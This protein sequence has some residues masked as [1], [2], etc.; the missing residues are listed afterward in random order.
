MTRRRTLLS[1]AAASALAACA[2]DVA[3]TH[4]YTLRA[5]PPTPVSPAASASAATPAA[6]GDVWELSPAVR[7]P[8]ALDRDTLLVESGS[9]GLQPLV[10]HRWAEPLRDSVPRLLLQ[11]LQRLRGAGRVW[12]APA[13]PGVVVARKLTVEV[14]VLQADAAR[15]SLRMRARWWFED[16][17]PAATPAAPQIGEADVAIEIA[18]G[19]VDAL[20]AAHRL[21]LWRLAGFV[22]R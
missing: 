15:R 7:L 20:A 17:A 11:D 10:G 18:D 8:G 4:W 1:L 19:S 22:S 14:L 21:A 2:R 16:A 13:P 6:G 9:S 12:A 5:D 3:P